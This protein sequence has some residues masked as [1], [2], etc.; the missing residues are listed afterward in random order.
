MKIRSGFVSNSS[1]ASF[2]IR[3]EC[4]LKNGDGNRLSMSDAIH[5]LFDEYS[6]NSVKSDLLPVE[7][8]LKCTSEHR[9]GVFTTHFYTSM[10]NGPCDFGDDAAQFAFALQQ[11]FHLRG[12]ERFEVTSYEMEGD[13]LEPKST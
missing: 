1:S 5:I 10:Y 3:W 6:S 7:H 13:S 12:K 8:A 4:Y 11:E 9:P 2:I